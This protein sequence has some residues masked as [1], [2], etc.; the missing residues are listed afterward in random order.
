[1]LNIATASCSRAS[2]VVSA[3]LA[4]V[5]IDYVVSD[6]R[7]AEPHGQFFN[8]EELYARIVND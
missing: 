5:V 4:L 1:M 3:S 8:D 7:F 6:T 2:F